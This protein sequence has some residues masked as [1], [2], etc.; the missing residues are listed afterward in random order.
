MPGY[1]QDQLW[2]RTI[3]SQYTPKQ[4]SQYIATIGV[5]P[6]SHFTTEVNIAD[7]KFPRGLET[8]S[9]I[10]KQHLITFPF[11]NTAMHYSGSHEIDISAQALFSRFVDERKGSFCFGQNSI[12]LE[13][14]RGLGF[15]AYAGSGRVNMN[16]QNPS[17]E[18]AFGAQLHMLVF[19]QPFDDSTETYVVDVGFGGSGLTRPIPLTDGS[20]SQTRGAGPTETHRLVKDP[21]SR[22]SLGKWAN[23]PIP[24]GQEVWNLEVRHTGKGGSTG[25]WKRVY[26]FT[27]QEFFPEDC[28]A[29]SAYV[30]SALP[31]FKENVMCIRY[32]LDEE[33]TH[34][35][36]YRAVLFG[37]EVKVRKGDGEAEVVATVT[38]ESERVKVL[39][40]FFGIAVRDEDIAFIEGTP[41]QL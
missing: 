6:E 19:V 20:G 11:E 9:A 22:S 13:M 40:E 29:A 24:S 14:L 3:P 34:G 37:R 2:I 21:F 16:W 25:A 17:K 7:G 8:L 27:E 32:I 31:L 39:G 38:T 35:D 30:T 23:S 5:L 33:S 1:L 18:R 12:L 36:L 26:A 41:A 4:V 15:R 10:V 28:V